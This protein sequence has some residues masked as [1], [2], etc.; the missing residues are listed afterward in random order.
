MK[1]AIFALGC[2]WKPE[3][4][5]SKLNGIINTEVGYCG[6]NVDKTTYET[7]KAIDDEV[8]RQT[9]E[10]CKGKIDSC[11]MHGDAIINGGK[12]YLIDMSPINNFPTMVS[13]ALEGI[14]RFLIFPIIMPK[15]GDR[16]KHIDKRFADRW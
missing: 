6:G 2:F 12:V 5:F 16:K 3:E 9:N 1:K 13:F 4:N 7:D 15:K 11:F 10:F 8:I 14:T